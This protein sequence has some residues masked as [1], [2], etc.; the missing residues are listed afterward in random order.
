MSF[1]CKARIKDEPTQNILKDYTFF[2]N[3]YECVNIDFRHINLI[4]NMISHLVIKKVYP[5]AFHKL[6]YKS[7]SS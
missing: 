3:C 1:Q 7:S 5:V 4:K 2:D 6:S